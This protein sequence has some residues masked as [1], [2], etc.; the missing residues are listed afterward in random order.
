MILRVD[1][2][3]LVEELVEVVLVV[4][5][6]VLLV[7][8]LVVTDV[9][10]SDFVRVTVL[11]NVVVAELVTELEVVRVSVVVIVV[12]S[13]HQLVASPTIF[14]ARRVTMSPVSDS[15]T[16]CFRVASM[17]RVSASEAQPEPYAQRWIER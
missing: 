4:L 16:S 6:E 12:V 1:V 15:P 3:V 10:V 5:V 11:V 17:R 2:V 8:E 13:E 14:V 9:V 7:V